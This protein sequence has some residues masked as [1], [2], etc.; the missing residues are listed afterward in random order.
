MEEDDSW[1]RYEYS[2][3]TMAGTQTH[4]AI[5]SKYP[6][7]STSAAENLCTVFET[8]SS[9]AD[10]LDA[11]GDAGT[12]SVDELVVVTIEKDLGTEIARNY[13]VHGNNGTD[14][15]FVW[16]IQCREAGAAW[17]ASTNLVTKTWSDQFDG[18]SNVRHTQRVERPNGNITL[19]SYTTEN[20]GTYGTLDVTTVKSG[21]P[22]MAG[23]DIVYGTKSVSK[24]S[25]TGA[26][27][28]SETWQVESGSD[29]GLLSRSEVTS[30][31]SFGRAT[32]M[33]YLDG[34][35]S[36]M[37]Y[38][39]CGV[40]S[41][42]SRQGLTTTYTYDSLNRLDQ[43]IEAV[44]TDGQIVTS[45]EY[46]ALGRQTKVTRGGVVQSEATY[47]VAGRMASSEDAEEKLTYYTY[48]TESETGN[49]YEEQRVYPH[50]KA[51]G[52]IQVTWT[53]GQGR[54]VRSFLAS[55][56]SADWSPSAP[57]G[58][59]TLTELSRSVMIYDHRGHHLRHGSALA[60]DDGFG[61]AGDDIVRY[62]FVGSNRAVRKSYETP[63]IRLDYFGGTSDTYAGL[64][65]FGRITEQLWEHYNTGTG[66]SEG[67]VF[68]IEH[69]YDRASNR[70]Y[71]D[72]AT[73][74]SAAQVYS[75]DNLHRLTDFESGKI[76][77]A[78]DDIEDHW[79]TRHTSWTLDPLGNQPGVE[80]YRISGDWFDTAYNDANEIEDASGH[81]RHVRSNRGKTGREDQ[82]GSSA[83]ESNWENIGGSDD[84][85][86][87]TTNAGYL[88]VTQVGADTFDSETEEEARAI[89][90]FGEAMGTTRGVIM[91][92]IPS[93][94]SGYGAEAGVVFGYKSANDYWLSAS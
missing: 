85:D 26:N 64:D 15:D 29:V 7:Q 48:G 55:T 89:L 1:A 52:P 87:H 35:S 90:L 28:V 12:D 56:T 10:Y 69:G 46:D 84:F 61:S 25:A 38:G 65:R 91:F 20:H 45:Y 88:T 33:T 31:D 41:S 92:N 3:D 21:S 81:D 27:I 51:S 62:D 77:S 13:S 57:S 71:A 16:S 93:A 75:Y 14:T 73:Y 53:D 5:V 18:D 39:C 50:S 74:K 6:S 63:G 37:S 94:L 59:E 36:S 32:Q 58:T 72:N 86:I 54:T 11:N 24:R 60:E 42:T 19:Y 8:T 76:S 9:S 68:R 70:L 30:V 79:R 82:F 43:Q 67:D 66:A 40:E 34:T 17:N 4:K 49:D 44:G 47:D 78:K 22:N 83:T 23:D 2:E 80:A